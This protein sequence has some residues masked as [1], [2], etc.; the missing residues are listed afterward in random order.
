MPGESHTESR[1]GRAGDTVRSDVT[2]VTRLSHLSIPFLVRPA[3]ASSYGAWWL[4]GKC[5]AIAILVSPFVC[6]VTPA[7]SYF[8][9]LENFSS[10]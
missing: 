9:M 7:L 4:P 10:F 1:C 5:A 2:G 3:L 6:I 8:Q